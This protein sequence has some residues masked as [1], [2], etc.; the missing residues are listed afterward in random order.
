[1]SINISIIGYSG[2]VGDEMLKLVEE[3]IPYNKLLL[4]G[5]PKDGK[6]VY[7]KKIRGKEYI[8]HTFNH[9]LFDDIDYV[10]LG[11]DKFTAYQYCGL[12]SSKKCIC[13]DNSS[14][15]RLFSHIPLIVPEINFEDINLKKSKIIANPNCSTIILLSAIHNIHKYCKINRL[16]V[17]TYQAVSGAGK[18]GLSELN[19]QVQ[20]HSEISKLN[21]PVFGTQALFNVFSTDYELNEKQQN[22]EENKII[23]ESSKILKDNFD[24]YPTCVRVPTLR[25]HVLSVTLTVNNPHS[26]E[27][28]IEFIK[29]NPTVKVI[30]KFPEPK[31]YEGTDYVIIGR[32]RVYKNIIQMIVLGDQIKKGAS[33]NAVNILQKLIF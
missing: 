2:L 31:D 1:M 17:S 14:A 9:S 18:N 27:Q 25:C 22:S 10:L 4:I 21:F 29:M 6:N 16:D 23:K 15:H 13:I 8:I 26:K 12:L 32:L 28:I 7:T 3:R 11:V 24:I 19:E 20:K 5:T 33:L 30:D